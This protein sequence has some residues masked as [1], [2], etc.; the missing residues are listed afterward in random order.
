[1]NTNYPGIDVLRTEC[2]RLAEMN[3]F[4]V[5]ALE[6]RVNYVIGQ[7]HQYRIIGKESNSETAEVQRLLDRFL[8]GND[9]TRRQ[10]E[11][12]RRRDRDGEV[13]IR[14]T[15]DRKTIAKIR[16][17]DPE[18]VYTPSRHLAESNTSFG[19]LTQP[20]DAEEVVGYWIDER[21]YDAAQIHHRKANVDSNTKRGVPLFA[22]VRTNLDRAEQLLRNMSVVSNIQ[23]SIAMIRRHQTTSKEA[24]RQFVQDQATKTICNDD[25]DVIR[26]Y[27]QFSPGTIIDSGSSTEYEFPAS[28][29][30]A[31]TY[32]SVL[33]AELR[34]IASRLVMPE[35]MLTS[36]ASNANYSSTMIAEG[37]AVRMFERLQHEVIGEDIQLLR[38]V[39]AL[40]A[41]FGIIEPGLL[42]RVT[43]H[44][45]PPMLAARDRLNEARADKILYDL[46]VLS[47][48]SLAMRYG[49]D[50]AREERLSCKCV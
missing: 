21:Y 49:I 34:A 27:Q 14:I 29:I 11:M 10:R 41:S 12:M 19:I 50:P 20:N 6:N 30:D 4:A 26:T 15:P 38:K 25:G 47:K 16:F 43:I 18:Q 35:F 28:A 48:E 1:M 44:T 5:N 33:Q 46:G 17:V 31:G 39:F 22:P 7:G 2:R 24:V 32:I 40:S 3:E 13:F 8:D 37:P 36:D 9:W 42:D 45:I 23:S